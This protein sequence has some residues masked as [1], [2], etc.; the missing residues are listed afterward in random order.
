MLLRKAL[1]LSEMCMIYFSDLP[2]QSPEP[3]ATVPSQYEFVVEEAVVPELRGTVYGAHTNL[4]PGMDVCLLTR[5]KDIPW[6][7]RVQEV[8][9]DSGEFTVHWYKGGTDFFFY[10]AYFVLKLIVGKHLV[11]GGKICQNHH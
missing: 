6:L 10:R 9:P 4:V 2:K 11:W 1:L 8:H 5:E 7:G 3:V